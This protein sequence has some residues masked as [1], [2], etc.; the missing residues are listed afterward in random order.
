[1]K[2]SNFLNQI[3]MFLIDDLKIGYTELLNIFSQTKKEGIT[4]K[5]IQIWIS[6]KDFLNGLM[7]LPEDLE[8]KEIALTKIQWAMN[9]HKES[10]L[11]FLYHSPVKRNYII[12]DALRFNALLEE[13][14][15]IEV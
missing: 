8:N 12:Y 11:A 1:M 14:N 9:N 3:G 7:I 13:L 2:D 6:Y 15:L 5:G 4:L 10:P